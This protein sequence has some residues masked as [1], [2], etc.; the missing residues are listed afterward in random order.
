MMGRSMRAAMLLTICSVNAPACV[1]PA[2]VEAGR[3]GVHGQFADLAVAVSSQV[4]AGGHILTGRPAP[5]AV[6]SPN[7]DVPL[8]LRV[9]SLDLP[10]GPW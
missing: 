5:G 4:Q 10:N 6:A 9:K 3:G 2:W 1:D 8:T 7:E